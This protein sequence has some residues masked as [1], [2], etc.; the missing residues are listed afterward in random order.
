MA[1]VPR[2]TAGPAIDLHVKNL[3]TGEEKTLA[4]RLPPPV[5]SLQAPIELGERIAAW[6]PSGADLYFAAPEGDHW[7]IRRFDASTGVVATVVTSASS[8]RDVRP[9]SEPG[10]IAYL[11]RTGGEFQLHEIGPGQP[12]QT[13]LRMRG[14]SS[15]L[16]FRGWLSPSGPLLHAAV[17]GSA[18]RSAGRRGRGCSHRR[19]DST[20]RDRQGRVSAL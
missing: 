8:I 20:S 12:D 7:A 10:R 2:Y 11:S 18:G 15:G 17:D 19:L 1:L 13:I 5:L 3:Q 16:F 9:S 6:A 4:Q 14:I